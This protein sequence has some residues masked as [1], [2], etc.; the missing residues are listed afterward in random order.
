MAETVTIRTPA[1]VNLALSVGPPEPAGT[2][3]AGMHPIASWIAA[4]DLFDDITLTKAD[5]TTLER[6]WADD[7]PSRSPMGWL[8]SDDLT[9]RALGKLS[10]I[11]GRDLSAKVSITKRIPVGGGL[12]GGSSDAAACLIAASRLFELD[13]PL[14]TLVEVARSLGS[15]IPFFLDETA[16]PRPALVTHFGERIRRVELGPTELLLILPGFGCHTGDVYREYDQSPLSLD[17][18]RVVKMA[19]A[20]VVN[21]QELFNDLTL[22]AQRYQAELQTLIAR[23]GRVTDE[24]IHLSGSGSTLF[25]VPGDAAKLAETI[26]D[27]INNVRC[28]V[29][30]TLTG[31]EQA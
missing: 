7:A 23:I 9:L 3:D 20:G 31:T 25:M 14:N 16:K 17:I 19:E 5:A 2:P 8:P 18:A 10:A 29:V 24:P 4:V 30:R 28:A 6:H 11:A 22:P 1:K 12:G 21:T 15:D 13:L 26:G 27:R